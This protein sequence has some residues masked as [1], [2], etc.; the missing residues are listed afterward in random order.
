MS[1]MY[2]MT[3]SYHFSLLQILKIA[4]TRKPKNTHTRKRKKISS[5][6]GDNNSIILTE[7]NNNNNN[8][9]EEQIAAT[10]N[11]NNGTNDHDVVSRTSILEDRNRNHT[12][13][14]SMFQS[15]KKKQRRTNLPT[16]KIRDITASIK[17]AKHSKTLLCSYMGCQNHLDIKNEFITL[18]RVPP[19]P[20]NIP[21]TPTHKSKLKRCLESWTR[22]KTMH[23]L[24][25]Y[26]IGRKLDEYSPSLCCC[27]VHKT[28]TV[29]RTRLVDIEGKTFKF[30]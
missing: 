29:K 17:A 28:E 6:D 22:K 25:M 2:K 3:R 1:R 18:T 11:T 16:S 26:R 4:K 10:S 24:Y 23:E 15:P 14:D 30:S 9:I 27:N 21:S 19:P 12:H 13:D 20:P 7:K 5:D 8:N